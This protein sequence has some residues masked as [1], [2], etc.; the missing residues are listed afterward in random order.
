MGS[1]YLDGAHG[2]PSLVDV[3]RGAGLDVS[4]VA[5]WTT[6]T[7]SSGGLNGIYGVVCHHTA[8]PSSST[9]EACRDYCSFGHPDSPVASMVLG[10]QGQL[11]V[12]CA[13]AAN[14]AGKGGP[15]P[16]S[17]GTIPL[18]D[19]NRWTIGV[20][21]CCNGTGER[22]GDAQLAAYE[23]LTAALCDAYGLD[24]A[25]DVMHHASWA[26][27]RK[28]DPAGPGAGAY[29]RAPAG[30]W[31][32][33]QWIE[34]V[35]ATGQGET[36][37]QPIVQ[38]IAPNVAGNPS[39]AWFVRFASGHL[40]WATNADTALASRL[41]IPA[42]A[43]TMGAD[44]YNNLMAQATAGWGTDAIADAI[45]AAAAPDEAPAVAMHHLPRSLPDAAE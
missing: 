26:P 6:N 2:Y 35:E 9:F 27:S 28:I 7:R 43:V 44:Q 39:P 29:C 41:G 45:A 10:R 36:Y 24:P 37:V 12:H 22:W 13:G 40:A 25:R 17:R 8:C 14:H 15:W 31:D 23:A 33:A 1:I 5:G 21:A 42:E 34:A 3:A 4:A 19:G 11:S 32:L 38:L 16:S 20:E 18:D 30:T